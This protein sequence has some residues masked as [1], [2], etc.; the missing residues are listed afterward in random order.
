MVE[1]IK[2]LVPELLRLYRYKPYLLE[3]YVGKENDAFHF[4]GNPPF[5]ENIYL[6]YFWDEW[7]TRYYLLRDMTWD[8]SVPIYQLLYGSRE[9]IISMLS[10]T[11][12]A[13]DSEEW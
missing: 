9:A 6:E 1:K 8:T 7:A 3:Y 13:Q 11:V 2:S 5:G 10:K 12:P 4:I